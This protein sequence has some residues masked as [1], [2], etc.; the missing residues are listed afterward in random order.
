[1]DVRGLIERDISMGCEAP[2][3]VELHARYSATHGKKVRPLI[4]R[5]RTRCRKCETCKMHRTRFWTGRAASEYGIAR[6]TYFVTL[7]IAPEQHARGD[8]ETRVR[9]SSKGVDFDGLPES[10]KF[11]ERCRTFG[12]YITRYID[13][14]RKGDSEHIRPRLR[15]LVVAEAH[16]S[17]STASEM[18]GRPHFHMLIHE[19]H[20]SCALAN[21]DEMEIRKYKSRGEWKPGVFLGDTA[22][23]RAGWTLGFTKVQLATDVGSAVYLCKYLTKSARVRIRASQD[24]GTGPRGASPKG[25]RSRK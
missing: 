16:D 14:V 11:E 22:W 23:L 3:D 6:V 12:E 13:R 8:A 1:M 20:D 4:V 9:L 19:Q 7:T 25:G 21:P 10:E 18:K 5:L 2:H 24:Y 15:Y 17:A